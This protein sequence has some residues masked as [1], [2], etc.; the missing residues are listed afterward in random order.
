MNCKNCNKGLI[1]SQNYCDNCGA[2][3]IRNR[4][5][6]KVLAQQ[7]NEQF[8][9]L[10]NKLFRTF[11]DLFKKPEDVIN[12]YVDGT[13][14]KY[15]DV[16]QY[17]AISLTIAGFQVFLMLTFFK[18]ALDLDMGFMEKLAEAP[19]NKNNPFLSQDFE[20]SSRY[21]GLIYIITL[22][23]SALSTW[24]AYY[25]SGDRRFNFTEHIVLNLY[26]SA[27][28]VIIT[29]VSSIIFLMFGL[30]Y[31]VVNFILIIPMFAY[32]FYILRRVFKDSFWDSFA[33]FLLV[34]AFYVGIYICI[35][36]LMVI[37]GILFSLAS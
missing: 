15:I 6:I 24:L 3:R 12:G 27:Q 4:L 29:A 17:F 2:K 5:T 26:Y 33:K 37:I 21:Q 32:L 8:L 7:V 34:A 20:S 23:L 18:E 14:K 30:N 11:L 25:I 13:R 9:S 35:G 28:I 10:D 31:L 36:I 19:A 22:P 1:A 16:I